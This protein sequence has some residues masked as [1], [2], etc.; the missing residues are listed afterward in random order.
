MQI[1]DAVRRAVRMLALSISSTVSQHTMVV[2]R[3]GI[4]LLPTDCQVKQPATAESVPMFCSCQA[5]WQFRPVMHHAE[6]C[7]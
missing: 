4:T 6:A 7:A 1:L 5:D 2:C 3:F